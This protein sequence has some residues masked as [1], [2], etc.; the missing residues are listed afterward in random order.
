MTK[1]ICEG[2]G[3]ILSP[4]LYQIIRNMH[5]KRCNSLGEMIGP[6]AQ[7]WAS[8]LSRLGVY[9]TRAWASR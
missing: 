7:P 5:I 8:V 3:H 9:V 1:S 4:H 2:D 6:V